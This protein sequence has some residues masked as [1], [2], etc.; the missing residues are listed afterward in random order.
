[1]TVSRLAGRP[2]GRPGPRR[3]DIR[4]GT[5]FPGMDWGVVTGLV[6]ALGG[7]AL[8]G[9]LSDRSQRRLLRESRELE[10]LKTL[11]EAYVAFLAAYRQFRRFLIT[12]P[13]DVRVMTVDGEDVAV[14]EG[15]SERWEA[16]DSAY[17]RV[18]LL[19]GGSEVDAAARTV[20]RAVRR[21]A[22]AR[23]AYGPG[24]VPG[25][26]LR[27]CTTA[28]AAF[29]EAARADLARRVTPT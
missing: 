9:W 13:V 17:A 16:A 29:A 21:V 11:Q 19:V 5:R 15:A 1:L 23:G 4:T 2:P 10:G 24:Q 28:E 18:Q 14:I 3:L 22:V 12:Q 7:V 27:L 8:G 26:L 20:G 6:G 25:D